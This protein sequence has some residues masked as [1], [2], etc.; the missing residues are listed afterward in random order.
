MITKNWCNFWK[1]ALLT[2]LDLKVFA[3]TF[4]ATNQ[5][6]DVFPICI[7]VKLPEHFLLIADWICADLPGGR[8]SLQL[9]PIL[10]FVFVWV[11]FFCGHFTVYLSVCRLG[12][13]VGGRM[14]TMQ[15]EGHQQQVCLKQTCKLTL[16][17]H[18]LH[19]QWKVNNSWFV[20]EKS[21]KSKSQNLIKRK[22]I[23]EFTEQFQKKTFLKSYPIVIP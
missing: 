12:L 16:S 19:C 4:L 23:Y 2:F 13:C 20:G 22:K 21:P 15:R 11:F 1:I 6:T 3:K 17:L 8:G 18:L 7:P 9:S 10:F 5:M 14:T